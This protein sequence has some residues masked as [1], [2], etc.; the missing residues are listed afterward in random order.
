MMKLPFLIIACIYAIPT[1][2][3][4]LDLTLET[5]L[6]KYCFFTPEAKK[7]KHTLDNS[8]LEF[9]NYK[10]SFLPEFAFDL[11]PLSFSHQIKTLQNPEDGSYTYVKDYMNSSSTSLSINQ[12]LPY[13]G[14]TFSV[15]SS[16]NML[17][18]FSD[19]RQSFSAT[20]VSIGYSQQLIGG[21]KTFKFEKTLAVR[22]NEKSLKMYIKTMADIQHTVVRLYM[23]VY[24]AKQAGLVAIKNKEIADT[25]YRAGQSRFDNGDL[26]E[27]DF[28]Q[29]ELQVSN[30]GIELENAQ[31]EYDSS[32]RKLLL[33]LDIQQEGRYTVSEPTL[34]LPSKLSYTQVKEHVQENS[35]TFLELSIKRTEAEQNLYSTQSQNRFNASLSLNYGLNQYAEEIINA[36]RHPLSQQSL[37][38]TLQ[39]PIFNWGINRNKNKI[40]ENNYHVSILNIEQEE[41]TFYDDLKDKVA[42]YNYNINLMRLS[43]KSYEMAWKRYELLARNFVWGQVSIFELTSAQKEALSLFTMQCQNTRQTWESYY[44]IRAITLFDYVLS[45][46]LSGLY[47]NHI[48]TRNNND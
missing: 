42:D 2:S 48:N 4:D 25:L 35:P 34:Q 22:N 23:D 26:T 40:A 20:P 32:L 28:L 7:A 38:L 9:E 31:K 36:Y 16:L 46:E 1:L 29:L 3:Q 45:S 21:I 19:K 5:A 27:P 30:A 12:R 39:I 11:S 43:A 33:C 10:K 47:T 18:E 17:S 44:L 13:V 8:T 15:R 6:D 14:G 24:L 37:S 41:N